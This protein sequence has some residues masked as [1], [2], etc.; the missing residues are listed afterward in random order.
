[1]NTGT[2][3][4]CPFCDL[5]VLRGGIDAKHP[6]DR[7]FFVAPVASGVDTNSRE[8]AAFAPTFDG[9]GGDA[10]KLGNLGDGEKIRKVV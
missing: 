6:E 1:L 5:T 8:F 10:E 2:P 3:L 9:E 4:G 7:L